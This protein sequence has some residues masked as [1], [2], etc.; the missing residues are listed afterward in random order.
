MWAM[1][2]LIILVAVFLGI[3]FAGYLY[4]VRAEFK[5]KEIKK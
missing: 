2:I 5:H 1:V 3:K 4:N